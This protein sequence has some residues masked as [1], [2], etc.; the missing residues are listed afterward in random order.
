MGR[1]P[2]GGVEGLWWS[3]C[4]GG[5]RNG[6]QGGSHVGAILVYGFARAIWWTTDA[7]EHRS[8]ANLTGSLGMAS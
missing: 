6:L 8:V 4:L 1:V 3:L 7:A 2:F 5:L